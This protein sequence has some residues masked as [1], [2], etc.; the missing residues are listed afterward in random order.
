M[1]ECKI[2]VLLEFMDL[3]SMSL[4][5]L[6]KTDDIKALQDVRGMR[7]VSENLDI[8]FTSIVNEFKAIVGGVSIK[9]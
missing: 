4:L 2:I 8:L 3:L 1:G 7:G 6:C 5:Q 9:E